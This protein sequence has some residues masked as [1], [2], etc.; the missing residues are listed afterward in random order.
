MAPR[1]PPKA[2]AAAASN[3]TLPAKES[4]LF[5]QLLQQYEQKQWKKGVKTADTIL[6]TKPDHGGEARGSCSAEGS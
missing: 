5:K 6:K 2:A 4:Q 1:A 3:K